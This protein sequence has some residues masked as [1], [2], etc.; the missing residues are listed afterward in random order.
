VASFLGERGLELPPEK[1]HLT[2]SEDGF[3]FLGQSGRDHGGAVLVKP[4]WKNV[5]TFLEEVR[6]HHGDRVA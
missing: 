1:T 4:S 3:D 6:D 2:R 5:S